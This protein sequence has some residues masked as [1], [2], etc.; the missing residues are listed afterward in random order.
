[1]S[2]ASCPLHLLGS[3]SSYFHPVALQC[4]SLGDRY[5]QCETDLV[6]AGEEEHHRSQRRDIKSYPDYLK[7][8]E[9]E[10]GQSGP[11]AATLVPSVGL[12]MAPLKA[13]GSIYHP[14][15]PESDV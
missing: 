11:M 4:K 2:E 13:P 14:T 6:C 5:G 12:V 3:T 15:T 1:M 9:K 10:T 8:R 7:G